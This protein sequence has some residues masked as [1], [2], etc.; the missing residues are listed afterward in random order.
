MMGESIDDPH[1]VESAEV[2]VAGLR[3]LPVRTVLQADKVTQCVTASTPKGRG[4]SAYEVHM[5]ETTRPAN[6]EPFAWI[7]GRAE[8]IRCGRC[9]GTYLHGALQ[10]PDVMEDGLD[11]GRRSRPATT[12]PTSTWRIGLS[13][14]QMNR[15][16]GVS[17]L[18]DVAH[19]Q[20]AAYPI[21]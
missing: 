16:F 2:S 17:F 13:A 4:F 5:G 12:P 6:A 14:G 7:D 20:R 21:Q 8:G 18:G 19:S 10:N 9:A 3:M 11:S 15:C 1:H